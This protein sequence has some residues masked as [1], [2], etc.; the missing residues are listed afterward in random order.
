MRTKCEERLRFIEIV[1]I[2]YN[3]RFKEV[4]ISYNGRFKEV[5]L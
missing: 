1:F 4:F 5:F 3:G 2:S